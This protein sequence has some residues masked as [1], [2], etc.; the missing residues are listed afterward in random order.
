MIYTQ[1]FEDLR[2]FE[3]WKRTKKHEGAKMIEIQAR[4]RG[5]KNQTPFLDTGEYG[6]PKTDRV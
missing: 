4:S 3:A 5:R 1:R 6:F 2:C